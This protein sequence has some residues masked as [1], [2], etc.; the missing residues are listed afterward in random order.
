MNPL[1]LFLRT[2]IPFIWRILSACLPARRLNPLAE[3]TCFRSEA[4]QLFD[5]DS[6]R[7]GQLELRACVPEVT[8]PI[9]SGDVAHSVQHGRPAAAAAN[10]PQQGDI[11][12]CGLSVLEQAEY[13]RARTGREQAEYLGADGAAAGA[14]TARE[15]RLWGGRGASVFSV[16]PRL[17]P[18]PR[19][20]CASVRRD[21]ARYAAGAEGGAGVRRGGHELLD[22]CGRARS[23]TG[24]QRLARPVASECVQRAWRGRFSWSHAE[25]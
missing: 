20:R 2:S 5:G 11:G 6:I 13:Y 18:R 25:V 10:G 19:P 7:L 22:G 4:H 17:R 16:R 1:A 8:A 15:T 21:A 23:A 12:V 3:I 14:A 9:V 24:G